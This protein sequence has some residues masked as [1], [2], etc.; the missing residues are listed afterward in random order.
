MS[1]VT[2]SSGGK[3][4]VAAKAYVPGECILEEQPLVAVVAGD[5]ALY[6]LA[7]AVLEDANGLAQQLC[8]EFG[9][10]VGHPPLSREHVLSRRL[11]L[12]TALRRHRDVPIPTLLDVLAALNLVVR[13]LCGEKAVAAMPR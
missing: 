4:L 11:Y 7:D 9:G 13:W 10:R 6:R 1:I 2:S 5:N 12:A 8:A 3:G